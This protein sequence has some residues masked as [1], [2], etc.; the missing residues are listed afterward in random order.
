MGFPPI[1]FSN[2][3]NLVAVKAEVNAVIDKYIG[4]HPHFIIS[5]V[6]RGGF[7]GGPVISEYGFLLGVLT[8]SLIES[9]K[10]AEIGFASAISIEPLI[11]L[12]YENNIDIGE[13]SKFI[14]ELIGEPLDWANMPDVLISDTR[15]DDEEPF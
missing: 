3:P 7:S 5:S 13:G 10:P 11:N 14:K 12:I 9:D 15:D 2:S 6:P 4:P 8:E 1:P